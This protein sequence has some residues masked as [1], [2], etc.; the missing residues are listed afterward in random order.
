MRRF[1]WVALAAILVLALTVVAVGEAGLRPFGDGSVRAAEGDPVAYIGIDMDPTGNE[2]PSAAGPGAQ[3]PRDRCISK[4]STDPDF[5]I[6]IYADAIPLNEEATGYNVQLNWSPDNIDIVNPITEGMLTFGYYDNKPGNNNPVATC[7]YGE[8]ENENL[9]PGHANAVTLNHDPRP[10]A[11][12][13]WDA[14][15]VNLTPG[16]QSWEGSQVIERVSI[17]INGAGPQIVKLWLKGGPLPI[18]IVVDDELVLTNPVGAAIDGTYDRDGDTIVDD[19]SVQLAIDTPCPEQPTTT[20]TPGVTGTATPTPT[21][22]GTPSP[23]GLAAGWNYVCYVGSGRPIE[24]ALAAIGAEVQAVYHLK[25][26]QTYE[27][28]FPGRSDISNQI[29]DLNPYEALFILMANAADWPQETGVSPPAS[30]ELVQ[31]WNSVCYSGETKGAETAMQGVEGGFGVVYALSA[32]QGWQQ[33]VPARPDLSKLSELARSTAVFILVT[34]EGGT[35]WT[36]E[37]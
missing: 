10:K 1:G 7:S 8:C 23:G 21:A 32:T 11:T 4:L 27:G 26:D 30:V 6:D 5:T 36:F 18:N 34:Q 16:E 3:G 14:G 35:Q 12:S 2:L 25:P 15:G 13:P 37:P 33:L 9:N 31:N 28:W 19:Y 24:E 29:T 20:P 17:D 22:T